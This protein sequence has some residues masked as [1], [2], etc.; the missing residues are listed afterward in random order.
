M[1]ERLRDCNVLISQ[2]RED[3]ESSSLEIEKEQRESEVTEELF[4]AQETPVQE[5]G[6]VES[7][8]E[9]HLELLLF[10]SRSRSLFMVVT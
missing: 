2:T 1:L 8:E 9:F 5:H 6:F 7:C 3:Q 10:C 4:G